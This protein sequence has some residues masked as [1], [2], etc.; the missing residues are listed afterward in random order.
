MD[1]CASGHSLVESFGSGLA[2]VDFLDGLADSHER[3]GFGDEVGDG[4]I[5]GCLK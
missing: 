2:L 1:R 3:V 4:L 5:D